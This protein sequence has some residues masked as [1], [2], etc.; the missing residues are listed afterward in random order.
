MGELARRAGVSVRTL[1]H[2]E[3]IGLLAPSGRTEAGHRLYAESEVLRLQ[4]IASLR[5]LELSLGEIR[6][7][8]NAGAYTPVRVVELHAARLRERIE[9]ERRLCERLE[10]VSALLAARESSAGRSPRKSW[11]RPS[12]R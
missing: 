11:S 4:Q 6:A 5:S 10:T 7:C 9:L 12:W 1:H 2:Y 3:G 8:L